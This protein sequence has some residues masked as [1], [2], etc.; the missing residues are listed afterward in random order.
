MEGT[1]RGHRQGDSGLLAEAAYVPKV[2][3]I[4]VF[5]SCVNVPLILAVTVI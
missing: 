4:F 1:D 2:V 3:L 5:Q